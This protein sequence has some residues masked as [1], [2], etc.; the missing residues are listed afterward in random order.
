MLKFDTDIHFLLSCICIFAVTSTFR[1]RRARQQ[2][3][4]LPEGLNLAINAP[5]C[6]EHT[7]NC[8]FQKKFKHGCHLVFAELLI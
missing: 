7:I 5:V 1:T 4:A 2:Q 6:F 3:E 8:S